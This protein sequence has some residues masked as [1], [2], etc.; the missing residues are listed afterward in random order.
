MRSLGSAAL[1][2]HTR[3]VDGVRLHYVCAGSP[4][5]P[6][7]L[8]LHGFPEYWYGW[9]GQIP[10]LA[11]AGYRVLALDQRGYNLSDK[12]QRVSDYRLG[13]LARDVV[14]LI[15]AL[16][17]PPVFLVGHDWGGVVAWRVLE[18]YPQY[19]RRAAVLNAPH[20]A[21]MADLVR[22]SFRQLR[23]SWYILFFQLPGL[24]ERVLRARQFA[25][26]QRVL[27]ATAGENAFTEVDM[28]RYRQAWSQPGALKAMLNWYRAAFRSAAGAAGGMDR[29][30]IQTPVHILWGARDAALVPE[31]ARLSARRCAQAE[32][33]YF[34]QASHWVQHDQPQQVNQAL[35]SFLA[36]TGA[37][38]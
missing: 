24:P 3:S 17:L 8:L 15:E 36:P 21:V 33:T 11:E 9:R 37:D 38:L 5:G 10:A 20:P 30:T 26:L 35:L 32:L 16:D 18:R 27:R 13:F 22:S 7:V 29:Q 12:P 19:V 28:Q 23:K 14:Q 31:L 2:S 1:S 6:P 34:K 4:E 25:A